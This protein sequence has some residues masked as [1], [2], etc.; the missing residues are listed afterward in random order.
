MFE[1]KMEEFVEVREILTVIKNRLLFYEVCFR[2]LYYLL[3]SHLYLYRIT[4]KDMG[5]MYYMRV[6]DQYEN[7]PDSADLNRLRAKHSELACAIRKQYLLNLPKNTKMSEFIR[8]GIHPHEVTLRK[9]FMAISDYFNSLYDYCS[10]NSNNLD[11][12]ISWL[13]V[14]LRG[15]KCPRLTENITVN[16]LVVILYWKQHVSPTYY[17]NCFSHLYGGERRGL[18]QIALARNRPRGEN[19]F[20][21]FP[22]D[23]MKMIFDWIQWSLPLNL[24]A[25]Y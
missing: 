14:L 7:A 21:Q 15:G 1:N 4:E 10:S 17:F 24:S 25:V 3:D 22:R 16:P 9:G 20:A 8:I 5:T 11:L 19:I 18:M 12:C 23:L 2:G 13:Y 6:S